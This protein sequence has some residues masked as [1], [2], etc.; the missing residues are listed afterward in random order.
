VLR[1]APGPERA[2]TEYS[3]MG[4]DDGD[5]IEYIPR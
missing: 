1:M 5:G 4:P 2:P 3:V